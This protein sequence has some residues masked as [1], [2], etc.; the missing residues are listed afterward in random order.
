MN[1][2]SSGP[3]VPLALA[4]Q[5]FAAFPPQAK[6]LAVEY[7]SVLRQTPLPL[8]PILLREIATYDWKFPLERAR[9]RGQ[10]A[11]LG[12]L[13]PARRAAL[14]T[15]FAA[16]KLPAGLDAVDWLNDPGGY[17]EQLTAALWSTGESEWRTGSPITPAMRVEPRGIWWAMAQKMP[18]AWA[19]AI[20]A[21][22]S[23]SVALNLCPPFS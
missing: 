17:M 2:I 18:R 8:L 5:N 21:L 22:C 11:W 13:T 16:L 10:L 7:L 12:S 4:V 20:A 14:A 9:I 19:S 15:P 1:R 23:S 6:A 3:L